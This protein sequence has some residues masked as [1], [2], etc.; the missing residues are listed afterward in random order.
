MFE[1]KHSLWFQDKEQL[2]IRVFITNEALFAV[3]VL[4]YVLF[5]NLIEV[6][7]TTEALLMQQFREEI[8][9]VDFFFFFLLQRGVGSETGSE[10]SCYKRLWKII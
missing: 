9:T 10:H 1:T 7:L 4:T 3:I 5:I 6:K 2:F 8:D